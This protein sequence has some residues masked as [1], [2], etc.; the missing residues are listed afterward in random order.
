MVKKAWV[1]PGRNPRPAR[2]GRGLAVMGAAQAATADRSE[3]GSR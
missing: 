2:M 1:C 3:E